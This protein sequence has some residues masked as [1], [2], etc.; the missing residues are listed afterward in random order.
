[1]F[2]GTYTAIVTPF[3]KGKIDEAALER[4]IRAQIRAGVD[5]IV[6][7]G[8]TGESPTV[9]YDEHVHIIA[10]SVK[11]AARQDQGARRH[12]RQFH[13]R[14]DLPHPTRRKGR[15]RRLAPGGALLQQAD[16]GGPVPALPRGR[17]LHALAHRALQHS[18]PV[19]HRDRRGHRQAPGAASA[20][21][22]SASR[23]R[24]ATR[25]A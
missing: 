25:T 11:F 6:P 5:G 2:T 20:R 8:T 17:A 18:R 21:T 10:L 1:M 12:G 19:R 4:L 22:S 16:A 3:R 13:Q 23:K 15:G 14:G 9:D 7:V 24:A